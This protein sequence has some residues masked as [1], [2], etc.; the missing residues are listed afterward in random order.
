MPKKG[1][2]PEEKQKAFDTWK[3]SD[4]YKQILKFMEV[5]EKDD[6]VAKLDNAYKD[7]TADWQ[8]ICNELFDMV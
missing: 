7:I 2:S 6:E 8:P 3:E 1:L 5:K 4:E